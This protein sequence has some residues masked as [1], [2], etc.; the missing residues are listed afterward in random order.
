MEHLT[1]H[2][3]E[4]RGAILPIGII[5]VDDHSALVE[6]LTRIFSAESDLDLVSTA[7]TIAEALEAIAEH[8]PSVVLLDYWLPDGNGAEATREILQRWPATRVLMFSGSEAPEVLVHALGA[9]C[10]G[11]VS[12]RRPWQELVA[13]VRA[14]SRGESVIQAD[15]LTE[16]M[17]QLTITDDKKEPVLTVRELEIL[18]L[19]SD[20]KSTPD[21]AVALCLS[22]H[23]IRNHIGNILAKLG[24]HSKLEAVAIAAHDGII[25]FDRP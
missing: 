1:K 2:T 15:E 20:A 19:L 8:E 4:P 18:E 17:R 14:A 7:S 21:I 9:G 10:V 25:S 6:G 5:V 22:I 12:K 16:L 24:A 23:T 11:F 13:S 3:E